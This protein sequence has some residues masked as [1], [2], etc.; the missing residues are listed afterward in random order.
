MKAYFLVSPHYRYF[1]PSL[2]LIIVIIPLILFD[3]FFGLFFVFHYYF[4]SDH[5]SQ[6]K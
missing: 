1:Q 6:R 4:P 3:Y 2:S 5:L